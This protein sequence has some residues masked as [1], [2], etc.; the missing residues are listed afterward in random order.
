MANES[1]EYERGYEDG[2]RDGF[3]DAA[4]KVLP[5]LQLALARLELSDYDGDEA[6]SMAA[7]QAAIAELQLFVGG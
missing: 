5:A 3:L 2:L 1:P 4:I 7:V 6:E